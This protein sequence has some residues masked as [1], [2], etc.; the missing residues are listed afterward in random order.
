MWVHHDY[1][2]YYY[3]Y[4]CYY[5]Y[6]YYFTTTLTLST[7]ASHAKKNYNPGLPCPNTKI[8]RYNK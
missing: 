5:Y 7:L 4:Y 1:Y 8:I 6:Y 3:Y 2:Y